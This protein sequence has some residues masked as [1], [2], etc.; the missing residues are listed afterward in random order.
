MNHLV[1]AQLKSTEEQHK[2]IYLCCKISLV[3]LLSRI[4][5]KIYFKLK[6]IGKHIN[7]IF[8]F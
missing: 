5:D 8:H 2:N 7:Y 1:V 3:D 6:I 4:F